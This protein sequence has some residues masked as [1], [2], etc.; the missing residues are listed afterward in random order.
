MSTFFL[1]AT[2]VQISN[3]DTH[4][5]SLSSSV[6][7][8]IKSPIMEL[9]VVNPAVGG[10]DYLQL[11]LNYYQQERFA[12][13]VEIQQQ[14]VIVFKNQGDRLQ[15]S[16]ALNYLALG[17]QQLGKLRDAENAIAQSLELLKT[18]VDSPE[19]FS[20]QGQALNN[21]GKILL[22]RGEVEKAFTSW[23]EATKI[24]Q[25]MGYRE[26]TIGSKL[27]QTQA[28]QALGFYRRT[29]MQLDEVYQDINSL[30][31]ENPQDALLKVK[32]LLNIGNTLRVLG[33]LRPVTG[34]VSASLTSG[35]TFQNNKS[36]Q[37]LQI[38]NLDSESVLKQAL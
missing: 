7:P 11:G 20:L 22:A 36:N 3:F 6:Q 17:Y 23:Q 13:A 8:I 14:A 12:K 35:N 32:G 38:E 21:Q 37:N 15:Q 1:L 27:N 26:G 30:R 24:Y 29:L 19:K 16:Q 33:N 31:D 2:L 4:F 28:L 10:K 9:A 34:N 25:R 5:S 18:E